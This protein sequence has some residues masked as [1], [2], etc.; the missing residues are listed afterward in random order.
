MI[1][2]NVSYERCI[3]ISTSNDQYSLKSLH[4][5]LIMCS[6]SI[7]D[8]RHFP[9]ISC[10]CSVIGSLIIG[11]LRR[12]VLARPGSLENNTDAND[13]GECTREA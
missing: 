4:Q 1:A 7:P 9:A 8:S 6:D 5:R 2:Q 11:S 12:V 3:N 10:R 13:D